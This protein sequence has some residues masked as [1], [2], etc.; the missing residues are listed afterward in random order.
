[1]SFI[2]SLQLQASGPGQCFLASL[3]RT[4][5]PLIAT[6][7]PLLYREPVTFD[8]DC[9]VSRMASDRQ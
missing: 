5:L 8:D 1:M 3:P 4:A 6:L 2:L 9:I 7:W